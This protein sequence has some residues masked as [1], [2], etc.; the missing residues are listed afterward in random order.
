MF[1]YFKKDH[2]SVNNESRVMCGCRAS[3]ATLKI[4]KIKIK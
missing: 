2:C 3:I 1:V 4:V